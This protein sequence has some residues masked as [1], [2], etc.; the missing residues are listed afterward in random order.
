MLQ[1][2]KPDDYVLATGESHSVRELVTLAFAET[3]RTIDWKG[4]AEKETGI[5]KKTGKVL[6]EVDPNYYRPTKSNI[7][8]ATPRRR[9]KSSAGRTRSASMRW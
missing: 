2:L 3:G 8:S 5:D 7:C 9:A 6:V 1:Q 4:K